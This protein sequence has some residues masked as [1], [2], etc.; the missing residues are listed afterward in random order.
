[1]LPV[2]FELFHV[3]REREGLP[4]GW[5]DGIKEASICFF[6]SFT[7]VFDNVDVGKVAVD[8]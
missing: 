8:D 4:N 1:M 2:R 5:T 6:A 3:E 7:K